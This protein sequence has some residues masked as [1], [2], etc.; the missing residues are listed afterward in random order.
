M[1]ENT[2]NNSDQ[3]TAKDLQPLM[4]D[5]ERKAAKALTSNVSLSALGNKRETTDSVFDALSHPGR[6]YILTYLLRSEGY[7]TMT[8]LV[9]YVMERARPVNTEEFRRQIAIELTHTHLPKLDEMNLVN[10]N[11]ERQL[12]SPTEKTGLAGPFLR[13]ALVQQEQLTDTEIQ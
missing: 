1:N 6:R 2:E 8:D 12:V 4:T 11:M 3:T 7:V 10:Y 13:V 5:T 9:D